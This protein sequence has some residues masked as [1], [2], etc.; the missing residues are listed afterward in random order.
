MHLV[1]KQQRLVQIF[2]SLRC[3]AYLRKTTKNFIYRIDRLPIQTFSFKYGQILVKNATF[4]E[5]FS[6]QH[7]QNKIT[8][9]QSGNPSGNNNQQNNNKSPEQWADPLIS[10]YSK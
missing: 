9:P 6:T 10:G 1:L 2:Q 3:P 8:Q 4:F 7:K 5:V